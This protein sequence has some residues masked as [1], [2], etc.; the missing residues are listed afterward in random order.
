MTRSRRRLFRISAGVVA[1][2][3]AALSSG[4]ALAG[5]G[6]DITL[7]EDQLQRIV[8]AVFPLEGAGEAIAVTLSAPALT[9]PDGSDTIRF[10]LEIAVSVVLEPGEGPL[11]ERAEQRREEGAEANQGAAPEDRRGRART[12]ARSKAGAAA[13]AAR[14]RAGE[15]VRERT[16][17]RDPTLL[18]GTVAVS[19]GVRYDNESGSLFLDGVTIEQLDID[20]LP[21]RFND[22]VMRASSAAISRALQ[23]TPIYEVDDSSFTGRLIDTLLRDI[24][25]EDRT[26]KVTI[27]VG[28]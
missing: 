15:A 3:A 24:T 2:F 8:N 9:I 16:A 13:G 19:S 17:D 23:Q 14:G 18:T 20:Q 11:A 26:L 28:S 5:D 21:Q 7:T 22:P 27:G 12:K 10:G 4:C 6:I 25:I 1:V